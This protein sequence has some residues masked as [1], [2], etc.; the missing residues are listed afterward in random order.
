V[1]PLRTPAELKK[2]PLTLGIV[3][4]VCL[5]L[6][7][8]YSGFVSSADSWWLRAAVSVVIFPSWPLAILCTWYLWIF[9]PSLRTRVG[10]SL[11]YDALLPVAAWLCVLAFMYFSIEVAWSFSFCLI[12]LGFVMRSL[13]WENVDTLV[14]GP[15]ILS[16]YAVPCYVH[17]F[18]FLFYTFVAQLIRPAYGMV[19]K[20]IYLVSLVSFIV[21]FLIRSL[22]LQSL[23]DDPK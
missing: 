7:L 2:F 3:L 21:G 10:G 9:Y 13:I 20:S 23:K 11:I 6:S 4:L 14:L 15:R 8:L 19:G 5:L 1:I 17:V 22:E 12:V 16:V 18:F